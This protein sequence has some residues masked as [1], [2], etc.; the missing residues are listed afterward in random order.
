M[1][2]LSFI[3]EWIQDVLVRRRLTSPGAGND[4]KM[5]TTVVNHRLLL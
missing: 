4:L 2:G 5:T 3:I 1:A